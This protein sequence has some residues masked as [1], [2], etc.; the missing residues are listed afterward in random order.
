MLERPN[1]Q[2]A[3]RLERQ[4]AWRA[5]VRAGVVLVPVAVDAAILE[6]LIQLHWLEEQDAG[7]KRAVGAAI[8]RLLADTARR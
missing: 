6:F 5:R 3:R 2:A 8:A 7:D 4:R 1:P